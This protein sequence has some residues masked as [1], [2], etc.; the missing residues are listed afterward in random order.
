MIFSEIF[1]GDFSAHILGERDKYY[2]YP[3]LCLDVSDGRRD[4][5]EEFLS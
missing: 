2:V 4:I 3:P 5:F 1:L